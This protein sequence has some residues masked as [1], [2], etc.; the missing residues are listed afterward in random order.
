M[1]FNFSLILNFNLNE[2]PLDSCCLFTGLT[3]L[4]IYSQPVILGGS[5][6][7]K[8]KV[9]TSDQWTQNHWQDSA[10]GQKVIDGSGLI[11]DEMVAS[12][13]YIKLVLVQTNF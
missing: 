9:T 5:G 4:H 1:N 3:T 11:F 12:R 6:S 10:S 7:P 13:F 8:I 2:I